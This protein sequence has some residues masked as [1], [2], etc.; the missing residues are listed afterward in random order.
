MRYISM[1]TAK[2]NASLR[3][4]ERKLGKDVE[5]ETKP[6]PYSTTERRARLQRVGV[7]TARGS[8][9]CLNPK[10]PRVGTVPVAA[11]TRD[12]TNVGAWRKVYA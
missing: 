10:N 5:K 7:R 11:V 2:I 3:E 4:E 9:P 1:R 12:H 8:V 6:R